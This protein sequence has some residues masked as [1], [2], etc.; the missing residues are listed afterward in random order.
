MKRDENSGAKTGGRGVADRT[1]LGSLSRM[2]QESPFTKW[3][4]QQ[5]VTRWTLGESPVQS[6][7][8][9]RQALIAVRQ[10]TRSDKDCPQMPD[11]Q[12]GA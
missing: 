6:S 1:C 7:F 10:H 12:V 9:R 5:C 11:V 2:T 3:P 8:H 4:N